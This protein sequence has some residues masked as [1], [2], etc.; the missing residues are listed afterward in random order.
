MIVIFTK[1]LFTGKHL[2]SADFALE[3]SSQTRLKFIRL[4]GHASEELDERHKQTQL[5]RQGRKRH[6]HTAFAAE[7]YK[8]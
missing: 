6:G 3:F 2:S 4:P 7:I 8:A 5:R 1:C